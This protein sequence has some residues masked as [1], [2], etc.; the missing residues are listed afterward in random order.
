MKT[1]LFIILSVIVIFSSCS[2]ENTAVEQYSYT[3]PEQLDDGLPVGY[4]NSANI[5]MGPIQELMNEILSG[6]FQKVQSVL[7][8]RYGKLVLEEYFRGWNRD[9]RHTLMSCTKSMTSA[10]FGIARDR[11]LI[12]DLDQRLFARFPDYNHLNSDI[13]SRITLRHLLTFTSGFQWDQNP[14]DNNN[15]LTQMV[16]SP[17][18]IEYVLALPMEAEPGTVWNYCGGCTQ[19]LAEIVERSS[20]EPADEFIRTNLFAPL[21]ITDFNWRTHHSGDVLADYGLEMR[22]RGM[23]KVGLLFLNRGIWE[24]RRIISEEWVE[25]STTRHIELSNIHGYGFQW[26]SRDYTSHLGPIFSFYASGNGGQRIMMFPSLDMV[27]VFTEGAY[28]QSTSSDAMIT[29]YI[30]PAVRQ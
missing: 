30:L 14:L 10:I 23:L 24:G 7:I 20:G 25:L 8:Y 21:G 26:W 19:L 22:P 29:G 9:M 27:V 17:D 1:T 18:M 3:V 6:S 11:G 5:A 2:Q 28:N 15:N 13:K 4:L 16:N 12:N